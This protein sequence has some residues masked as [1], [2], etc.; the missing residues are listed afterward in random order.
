[1]DDWDDRAELDR[2]NEAYA[3]QYCGY[4]PTQRELNQGS[5]PR[6]CRRTA[7]K[8]KDGSSND[9]QHRGE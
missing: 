4:V 1:M 6:G 5:C 7:K 2:R 9:D 3:C 8:E